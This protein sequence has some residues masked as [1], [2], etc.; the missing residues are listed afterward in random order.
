MYLIPLNINL[1]TKNKPTNRHFFIQ[2][3]LSRTTKKLTSTDR[4]VDKNENGV[5]ILILENVK[6]KAR[7]IKRDKE[8]EFILIKN[9]Q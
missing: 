8:G 7:R 1:K 3:L 5:T 4:I 9:P 6:F 2:K